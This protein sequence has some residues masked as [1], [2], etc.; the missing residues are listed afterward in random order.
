[1]PCPLLSFCFFPLCFVQPVD[2]I[3]PTL[4]QRFRDDPVE[5]MAER[6]AKSQSNGSSLLSLLA[7]GAISADLDMR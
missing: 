1:M 3:D 5:D 4:G 2:Q 6:L 7:H